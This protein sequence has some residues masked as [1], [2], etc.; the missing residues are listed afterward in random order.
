MK[1]LWQTLLTVIY[2]EGFF[3]NFYSQ[4]PVIICGTDFKQF[5]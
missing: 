4:L 1:G 2:V 3:S 5:I